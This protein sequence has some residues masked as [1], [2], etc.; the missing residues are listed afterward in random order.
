MNIHKN[1]RLTFVRRQEMVQAVLESRLTLAAAAAA[2]GV[3]VPTVR[4]WVGRFLA[5]GDAGLRDAS[6]RPEVSPRSIAPGVA[7]AIVELRRRYLTHAA[8]GR[9]LSLSAS[10][11]GRVL[12]RAGLSRWSDLTPSE[13]IVRYEHAHPGDLVHLDTKKLGRIE[14]M[15]HR[16]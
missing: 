13:P 10:T 6:S 1:A 9:A 15:S 12:R 3:S 4:K 11:V 2:H 14:R 5:Q 16:V 8:I 7:V